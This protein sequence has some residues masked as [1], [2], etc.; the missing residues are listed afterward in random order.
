MTVTLIVNTENLS[1]SR[2]SFAMEGYS[3]LSLVNIKPSDPRY[4]ERHG[5][6]LAAAGAYQILFGSPMP[7]LL[8]NEDGKP[9]FEGY[10]DFSLESNISK[11]EGKNSAESEGVSGHGKFSPESKSLMWYGE[12]S[13]E[14]FD[15]SLIDGNKLHHK[16]GLYISLS[17]RRGMAAVSFSDCPVG[18][19]IE[20]HIA[21]I[22]LGRLTKK[23]L[24]KIC[25]A[26]EPLKVKYMSASLNECGELI[27]LSEIPINRFESLASPIARACEN[28]SSD[29]PIL[30]F[31]ALEAAAKCTGLG[32]AKFL[33]TGADIS[34][35][36]ADSIYYDGFTVTT[37]IKRG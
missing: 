15:S 27:N 19:D 26:P 35:F 24:S 9:Y 12:H 10:G 22:K 31:T 34:G 5:V 30:A 7:K 6:Y 11:G 23:L 36:S 25:G 29:N 37:F 33:G 32:I 8:F 1:D 28:S 13:P 3:S 17:H 20:G 2:A 4:I 16:D 21:K 18:V 14:S